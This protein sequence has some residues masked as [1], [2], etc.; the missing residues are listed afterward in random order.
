MLSSLIDL[1]DL[2][3]TAQL[4]LRSFHLPAAAGLF[5][6]PSSTMADAAAPTTSARSE[7]LDA[8]AYSSWVRSLQKK[9]FAAR[10]AAG[11]PESAAGY[12]D[13]EL[14]LVDQLLGAFGEYSSKLAL[15]SDE[16]ELWSALVLYQGAASNA[17]SEGVMAAP[18]QIQSCIDV[19]LKATQD[20]AGMDWMAFARHTSLLLT[21]HLAY[22]GLTRASLDDDE[23]MD[24][25]DNQLPLQANDFL[26]RSTEIVGG[27]AVEQDGTYVAPSLPR[28]LARTQVQ[29]EELLRQLDSILGE[30]AVRNSLREAYSRM[31]YHIPRVSLMP[32]GLYLSNRSYVPFLPQSQTIWEIYLSFEMTH[33]QHDS[34]NERK[35]LVKQSFLSRVR[36]PHKQHDETSQ[37]LSAFVSNNFSAEE[38][39]GIMETASKGASSAKTAY[40][41]RERWEDQLEEAQTSGKVSLAKAYLRWE[42]SRR[43]GDRLLAATLYARIIHAFAQPPTATAAELQSP[44]TPEWEAQFAKERSNKP[45]K[46]A[47]RQADRVELAARATQS[48]DLW[49][50]YLS[51]LVSHALLDLLQLPTSTNMR[52]YR[53]YKRTSLLR[54]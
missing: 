45:K 54:K 28:V 23:E 4:R 17:D 30:E 19:H 48:E 40:T 46:D 36:V 43:P 37:R 49:E 41:E 9:L 11:Q 32:P 53:P 33:L 52:V 29:D 50:D 42:S 15:R 14:Q 24:D 38:Y 3:I 2:F 21:W 44:P 34:S 20:G 18:L 1:V 13:E 12:R 39:E 27:P 8:V 10:A 16:W 31:A 47:G 22:V 35:E 5:L 51:Y 25:G 6:S 7:R 26:K